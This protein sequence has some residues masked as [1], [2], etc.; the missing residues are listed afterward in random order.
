M[1]FFSYQLITYK[2]TCMKKH[3]FKLICLGF[4]LLISSNYI[5]AQG[6]AINSNGDPAD[7]SAMIDISSTTKGTLIT[8]MTEAQR[9]LIASP[10]LGLQVF[11]TTS[12]CFNY[13]NG[14]SWKQIC[15]ECPF[16][17]PII[18][19]NSPVCVGNSLNLTSSSVNGATF[20]WT[21][22]NGFTS[23]LQNP[24][25]DNITT[26]YS[27]VFSLVVTA[28][29]CTGDPI[30]TLVT[31]NQKPT[32]NAGPDQYIGTAST[33]LAATGTGAWSIASGTGGSIPNPN[34]P[35][36]TFT[37]TLGSNYTLVWT[38]T[39]NACST[40]DTMQIISTYRKVFVTSIG[41]DGNLG[42]L[43]GADAKCMTRAAAGNLS[44]TYK[45]WLSS[46]TVNA[47]DRI[48]DGA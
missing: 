41:Y 48:T 46:S 1:Y 22:P 36:G 10:A 38:V 8:R 19:S 7:P 15:G 35:N 12:G 43:A 33:A 30:L 20:A 13:W 23:N 34:S 40:S 14:I 16:V 47:K 11:N 24:V 6:A 44:G 25:I 9:D 18:N 17:N 29:G 3:A 4:G 2:K 39:S 32:A 27:G 31:V 26:D 42:G 28:N 21:G 37:G 5:F 45:A